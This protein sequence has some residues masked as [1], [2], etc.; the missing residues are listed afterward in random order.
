V[1]RMRQGEVRERSRW[2]WRLTREPTGGAK[3][4]EEAVAPDMPTGRSAAGSAATQRG[5]GGRRSVK[6]CFS[7]MLDGNNQLGCFGP[8]PSTTFLMRC[9]N[10]PQ[11]LIILVSF[12]AVV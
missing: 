2:A 12:L 7:E 11:V 8:G 6:I 4:A 10:F 5:Q 3:A 9:G 1:P